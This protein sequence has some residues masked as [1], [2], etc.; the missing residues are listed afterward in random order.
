VDD[1]N[2]IV[3][4]GLEPQPVPWRESVL[5]LINDV[6]DALMVDPVDLANFARAARSF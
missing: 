1:I 5:I 3:R 6:L 2:L 4:S